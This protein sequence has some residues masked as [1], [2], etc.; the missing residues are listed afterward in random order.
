MDNRR[1]VPESIAVVLT[2]LAIWLVTVAPFRAAKTDIKVDYDPKFSFAGLRT[3]AWHPDGS[4]EVKL[5]VADADP[6]A[7]RLASI[8]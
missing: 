4:G 6:S 2:A 3:W 1:R 8:P 7:G 5:A